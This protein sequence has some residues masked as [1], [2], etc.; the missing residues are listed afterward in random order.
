[1]DTKEFFRSAINMLKCVLGYCIWS[2]IVYGW[3]SGQN[4]PRMHFSMFL[5]L[6]KKNLKIQILLFMLILEKATFYPL[7]S[8]V[9]IGTFPCYMNYVMKYQKCYG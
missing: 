8:L 9:T 7:P 3:L 4:C 2:Y 6:Q 5:A 1:M